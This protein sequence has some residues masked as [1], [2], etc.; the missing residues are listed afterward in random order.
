MLHA[1]ERCRD[2]GPPGLRYNLQAD[3]RQRCGFY[4]ANSHRRRPL[5]QI[6]R[7]HNLAVLAFQAH[8]RGRQRSK[9][10][11]HQR[12]LCIVPGHRSIKKTIKEM[13][14]EVEP[15]PAEPVPEPAPEPAE[16]VPEP[17]PP[18]GTSPAGGSASSHIRPP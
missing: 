10:P 2:Q 5:C 1:R 7:P 17:A 13:A 12:F 11:G 9:H 6:T 15:V 16:P 18:A 3:S 8:R 14:D 4:H